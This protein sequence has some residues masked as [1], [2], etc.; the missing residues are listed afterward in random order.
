MS[1]FATK[2][3][4]NQI[5]SNIKP[6]QVKPAW[7]WNQLKSCGYICQVPGA[8]R[9]I[10][11]LHVAIVGKTQ[12]YEPNR[13]YDHSPRNRFLRWTLR[14]S[15]WEHWGE[16]LY[17]KELPSLNQRDS[18]EKYVCCIVYNKNDSVKYCKNGMLTHFDHWIDLF[19][20]AFLIS[21]DSFWPSSPSAV[22]SEAGGS[23]RPGDSWS[24]ASETIF[25]MF[26]HLELMPWK[27]GS[28]LQYYQYLFVLNIGVKMV[29][30]GRTL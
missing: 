23:V 15:T 5:S 3:I 30:S 8:P 17:A 1:P 26:L 7:N 20:I 13:F 2:I 27:C 22:V 10:Y 19:D 9:C 4:I 21:M 24:N 14:R 16:R 18:L 12:R 29:A 28:Y 6:N 25:Y 11:M